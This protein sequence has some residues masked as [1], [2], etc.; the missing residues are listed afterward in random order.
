MT[1]DHKPQQALMGAMQLAHAI[2]EARD[3]LFSAPWL[4][5]SA[6]PMQEKA[7]AERQLKNQLGAALDQGFI[8]HDPLHPE[9][10]CFDQHSQFGLF[11]PDNRYHIATISSS[12]TYVIR[13]KRGSSAYMEVQVG[14]GDAG[15]NENLTSPKTVS[16]LSSNELI[17]EDEGY[18]E[19]TISDTQTGDNWLSITNGNLQATSVLIRESFM[20]WESEKSGTWYIE[21]VDTRGEPSPAPNPKLV[22]EQYKRASDYLLGSTKGWVKF[23]DGLRTKIKVNTLTPPKETKEGLPGQWNSAGYFPIHPDKA[24]ILTIPRSPAK[25]QSIQIGDLWFNALDYCHRQTSLNMSQAT[26]SQDDYAK[27]VISIRDPGVANWL[28][29]AGAST[30]FAFVRW[31]GL[32]EGYQF[33]SNPTV[34]LVE[35]EDLGNKLA[36]E[37][38]FDPEQRKEQLAA[39]QR[40]SLSS[41]RGY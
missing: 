18:F 8:V 17:V 23:V 15:F 40:A 12:G 37:P 38:C 5:E 24:I 14:A 4:L 22:H 19:I 21:R 41:A 1:Y 25:Y 16:Q 3:I 13:G 33:S 32:P 30:A 29:P 34:E 26:A 9:F 28:D 20:D 36:D 6:N 7:A 31:Q 39:R 27:F 10:R 11:N 35:F 2:E